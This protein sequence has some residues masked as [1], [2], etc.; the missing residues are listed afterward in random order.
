MKA[1]IFFSMIFS[2]NVYAQDKIVVVPKDTSGLFGQVVK[3]L[4]DNGYFIKNGDKEFGVIRT[5]AKDCAI[6]NLE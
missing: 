3:T 4:Y 5:E 6:L 1:L 2:A